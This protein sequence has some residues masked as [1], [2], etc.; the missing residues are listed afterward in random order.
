MKILPLNLFKRSPQCV[1]ITRGADESY[2]VSEA[3]NR[4]YPVQPILE[5]YAK[6][7]GVDLFVSAPVKDAKGAKAN[8]LVDNII[9]LTV[10]NRKNSKTAAT[11]FA[12]HFDND[13]Y[14]FREAKNID[15]VNSDG[16]SAN[17]LSVKSFQD[18]FIR[19]IFRTFENLTNSVKNYD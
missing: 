1:S 10:S 15:L 11:N 2:I 5:G 12:V 6:A 8:Q 18:N 3:L 4:L 13:V 17:V 9:S 16:V 19:A 14:P 7:H